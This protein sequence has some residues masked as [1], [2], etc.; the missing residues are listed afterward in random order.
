[1][2]ESPQ[3]YLLAC[4][5]VRKPWS[6]EVRVGLITDCLVFG[7][8]EV[9]VY[10]GVASDEDG[11][12]LETA[13]TDAAAAGK[14]RKTSRTPRT[15]KA[16]EAFEAEALAVGAVTCIQSEYDKACGAAEALLF[17]KTEGARQAA[18][19]LAMA[20][21]RQAV[22]HWDMMG[23]QCA[24]G[25]SGVRGGLDAFGLRTGPGGRT[26]L[27]DMKVTGDV[28][29]E[30]LFKHIARMKW[31]AQLGWYS[32]SLESNYGIAPDS[33]D[34]YNLC[35]ERDPPHVVTVI[36]IGADA[37]DAGD[38]SIQLWMGK[39]RACEQSGNWGGY[40]DRP[41]RLELPGWADE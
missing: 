29:P 28:S 10:R 14:A 41:V 33:I 25:I 36:E 26:I 9:R 11:R 6:E 20:D 38:R 19:I 1:M 4:S 40:A 7:Q 22:L 31:H 37:I 21:Q 2:N 3:H 18:D 13:A 17:P 23:F 5:E 34:R 30:T 15:G 16:W 8:R 12:A 32:N 39:L 24:S 35:V 27:A